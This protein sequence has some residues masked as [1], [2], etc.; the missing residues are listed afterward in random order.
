MEVRAA[1]IEWFVWSA[2]A[3]PN[4]TAMHCSGIFYLATGMCEGA[5][6]QFG[7]GW[8]LVSSKFLTPVTLRP[9]SLN[10]EGVGKPCCAGCL[11]YQWGGSAL[12]TLGKVDCGG[13]RVVENVPCH[14]LGNGGYGMLSD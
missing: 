3:C 6:A 2:V 7:R 11:I 4:Y 5:R 10:R 14:P 8:T 1:K 12:N 13:V 9:D